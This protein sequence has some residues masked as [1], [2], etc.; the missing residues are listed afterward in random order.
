MII[1]GGKY[2]GRKITAPD[3]NIARPTL[4][5][6]RM[7]VFNMLYSLFGTFEDKSFID[8]FGGSGII[9]IEALSRGFKDVTVLEKNP[10]ALK[11]I[12]ENYNLIGLIPNL[13]PGDSVKLLKNINRTFDVVY[14]D[15]P[16][17]NVSLYTEIFELV[18]A[19]SHIIAIEHSAQIE[20]NDANLIKSKKYG[21]TWISLYSGE[22]D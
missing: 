9:G 13:M 20:I 15:P 8:V 11:I 4:S 16:Y 22:L 2:K 17:N 6:V 14:L 5:K 21:G 10:K 12:K 3:E 7:G 1:T 18:K 19:K